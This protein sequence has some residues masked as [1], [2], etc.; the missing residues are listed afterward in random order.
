LQFCLWKREL[1][2]MLT[3]MEKGCSKDTPLLVLCCSNGPVVRSAPPL[4]RIGDSLSEMSRG[5]R[6]DDAVRSAPPL[7]RIGDSLSEMSR[8]LGL[9]DVSR[10]WAIFNV[11]IAN[12][13]GLEKALDWL[14]YRIQKRRVE[15][16]YHSYQGKN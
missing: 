16:E 3:G 7:S 9:D 10:P 12:M 6:L 13:S 1:E 8:G 11:D 15:L 14:L 4:S 2:I 5:L